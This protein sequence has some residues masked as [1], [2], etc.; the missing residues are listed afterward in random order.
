MANWEYSETKLL[1]EMKEGYEL[2]LKEQENRYIKI[3]KHF[4]YHFIN[5]LFHCKQILFSLNKES[6]N[7][8][9]G[10]VLETLDLLFYYL[11]KYLKEENEND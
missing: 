8:K 9:I 11:N 5:S 1:E 3:D 10:I 6:N 7:E 4:L 2:L